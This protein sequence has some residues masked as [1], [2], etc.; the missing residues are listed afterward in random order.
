MDR[1]STCRLLESMVGQSAPYNASPLDLAV[2]EG[3]GTRLGHS[4]FNEL[5]LLF[6]FD[7]V[8]YPFFR[9][10]LGSDDEAV[11]GFESEEELR[12]RVDEFRKVAMLLYGNV[13]YGFKRLSVDAVELENAKASMQPVPVADFAARHTPVLPVAPILSDDAYLTG[14]LIARELAQRLADEPEDE[15]ARA[16]EERR[17]AVVEAAKTNHSAYLAS[18]HLDVYVA[19]SMRQKAE[20]R[21]VSTIASEIFAHP[22][23][24]EMR[25]R[26]FDPTQAYCPN[27]VDKG[28]AE[29]LM[30][31]RAAC[32]IYLIQETDTLGKDSELASTLAQGKPVIAFIPELTEALFEA[33]LRN[34]ALSEPDVTEAELL[35]SQLR[36]FNPSAPWVE[37]CVRGWCENPEDAP[38]EALRERLCQSMRGQYDRRAKILRDDHPL[39][40]QVNLAT[41]VA[42]GVL[43]VRTIDDC[44][45]LVRRI[46]TGTLEFDI[47]EED[48]YLALQERVS[49]CIFRVVTKDLMLTNSFWNHYVD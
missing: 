37:G 38:I 16:L 15:E 20:F 49:K 14:Y 44:A 48:D 21:A 9:F 42:N 18:D 1:D 10:L 33:H 40:I 28:L 6:G 25:L 36:V 46:L 4:Q 31:R 27:R 17:I 29:A 23:L 41:G 43:V 35:L 12:A 8:S 30:L 2:L 26:Y 3:E 32:T 19:T 7:R 47:V 13:K 11:T 45:E 5:L 22:A 24:A 39:G 34:V